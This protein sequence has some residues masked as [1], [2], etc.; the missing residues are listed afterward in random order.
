MPAQEHQLLVRLHALGGDRQAERL[1]QPYARL[2]DR[3]VAFVGDD[4]THE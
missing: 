1:A 2:R 3:G 4:M